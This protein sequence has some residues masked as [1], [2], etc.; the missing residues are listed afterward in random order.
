M[1]AYSAISDRIVV[2]RNPE[3]SRAERVENEIMAPIKNIGLARGQLIE[4]P[5]PSPDIEESIER[6]AEILHPGDR[7]ISPAGD[8]TGNLVINA[9]ILAEVNDVRVGFLPYGNFNDI[10]AT[11]TGRKARRDPIALLISPLFI[12]A[13][14]L[15]V[16]KDGEHCRYALLYANLGWT[17][18]VA[19]IF[20]NPDTR[21]AIQA[22]RTSL[23]SNLTRLARAYFTYRSTATLPGFRVNGESEVHSSTTDVLAVNGPIMG[24]VIRSGK[25]YY[26]GGTFLSSELDVSTLFRNIPFLGRSALNLCIKTHFKLPG[27]EVCHT[28][29]DFRNEVT[30][31]LQMDGEYELAHVH[32]LTIA[33]DTTDSRAKVTIITA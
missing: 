9:S 15:Q 22:G 18:Q 3:S 13:R 26:D 10:A 32:T 8:G 21:Q 31:P 23:P 7:V 28:Q 19:A 17:A 20:D 30:V 4:F 11:F 33:K 27:T 5:V 24:K 1:S 29:L 2:I 12:E 14:P 16:L 6:L 25:P